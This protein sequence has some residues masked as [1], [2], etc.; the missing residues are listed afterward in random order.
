M[1]EPAGTAWAVGPEEDRSTDPGEDRTGPEGG[2]SSTSLDRLAFV[3][4]TVQIWS[5]L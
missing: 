2:R 1:E 4:D 5:V 3:L